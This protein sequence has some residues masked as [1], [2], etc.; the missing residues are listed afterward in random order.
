MM[1]DNL[2]SIAI[3]YP[4]SLMMFVLGWVGAIT[5]SLTLLLRLYAGQFSTEQPV[6]KVRWR[7]TS[8]ALELWWAES[9]LDGQR[10]GFLLREIN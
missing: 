5:F 4:S 10:F 1:D 9:V 7:Q 8:T 6:G 2:P 3:V